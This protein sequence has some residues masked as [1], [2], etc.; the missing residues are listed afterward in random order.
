[1]VKKENSNLRLTRKWVVKDT[2]YFSIIEEDPPAFIPLNG[3]SGADWI[4]QS[5]NA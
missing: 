1:M 3:F 4:I 2:S 5:T